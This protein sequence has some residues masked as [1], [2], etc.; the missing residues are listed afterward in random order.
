MGV[1]ATGNVHA[2][3]R[4]GETVPAGALTAL[5]TALQERV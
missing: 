5:G 1:V 3:A 2:Q 4:R